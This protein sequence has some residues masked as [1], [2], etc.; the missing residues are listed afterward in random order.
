MHRGIRVNNIDTTGMEAVGIRFIGTVDNLPVVAAACIVDGH[1]IA[2]ICPAGFIGRS[3]SEILSVSDVDRGLTCR[4]HQQKRVGKAISYSSRCHNTTIFNGHIVIAI[5]LDKI[6]LQHAVPAGSLIGS[7]ISDDAGI[8]SPRP[9]GAEV[10]GADA[11]I[12][13][14]GK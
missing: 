8:K 6:A 14:A 12:R 10:V 1:P 2:W 11:S 9:V 3:S 13:I 7:T 4:F 5:V